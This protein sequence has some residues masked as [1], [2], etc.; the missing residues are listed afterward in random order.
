MIQLSKALIKFQSLIY[1][2]SKNKFELILIMRNLKYISSVIQ[3]VKVMI[4]KTTDSKNEEYVN[5]G[6]IYTFYKV[7]SL[8]RL[9]TCIEIKNITN[10]KWL[11]NRTS[12][13]Q[14]KNNLKVYSRLVTRKLPKV[15]FQLSHTS[16]CIYTSDWHIAFK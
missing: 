9:H 14:W 2:L 6:A 13:S 4:K 3:F 15:T 7:I 5:L 12:D 1:F 16:S 10:G 8:N 11:E